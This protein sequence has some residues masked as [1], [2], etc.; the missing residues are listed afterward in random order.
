M[1]EF[2]RSNT[3]RLNIS[4][5]NFGLLTNEAQV[6]FSHGFLLSKSVVVG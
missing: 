3:L 2:F 6:H 1:T 5:M 4:H